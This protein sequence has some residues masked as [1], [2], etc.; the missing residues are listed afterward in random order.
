MYRL[1]IKYTPEKGIDFRI[2]QD[3]ENISIPSD[4]KMMGYMNQEN[5]FDLQK[6]DKETFIK[7]LAFDFDGVEHVQIKAFMNEEDFLYLWDALKYDTH[8]QFMLSER[9]TP[10]ATPQKHSEEIPEKIDNQ[11][12]EIENLKAAMQSKPEQKT[13]VQKKNICSGVQIADNSKNT[14]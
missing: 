8:R 6:Q 2:F 3:E 13:P 10:E 14:V 7:A 5:N 4:S 1:E 9:K 12:K 11:M